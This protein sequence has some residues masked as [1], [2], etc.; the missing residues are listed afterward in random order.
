LSD[1]AHLLPRCPRCG[2]G[3]RMVRGYWWCD[4]C[5]A[6]L[7]PPRGPSIRETF[8]LAGESL[9]RFLRATP[10]RRPTLVHP[11][12]VPSRPQRD[13]PLARCP[14]CGALTPSDGVA[15]VHCGTAFGRGAEVPTLQATRTPRVSQRDEIVYR[16]IVENMGEISLSK[17]STDLDMT[18]SELQVSIRRLEDS[19]KLSRDRSR[20]G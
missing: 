19:G 6:P 11:A 17:A 15:C 8:R 3:L 10:R 7:P 20:G 5:R 13:V 9:R 16:Y 12:G 4:V 18:A 2:Y 1:I 14:K